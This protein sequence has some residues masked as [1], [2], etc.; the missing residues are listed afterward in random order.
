[1]ASRN[2]AFHDENGNNGTSSSRSEIDEIPSISKQTHTDGAQLAK[3][4]R[5]MNL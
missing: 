1:M 5:R 2:R 3:Y 4:V